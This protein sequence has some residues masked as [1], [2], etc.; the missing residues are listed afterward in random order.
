MCVS[1][2]VFPN[3]TVCC[4]WNSS[5]CIVHTFSF[6]FV[7]IF[8]VLNYLFFSHAGSYP[9]G[10]GILSPGK[11]A[12]ASSLPLTH[13]VPKLG[14]CMEP[15]LHSSIRLHGL[16]LR[17]VPFTALL[18][19]AVCSEAGLSNIVSC[20]CCRDVTYL[21]LHQRIF[22]LSSVSRPALGPTQPPLQW[23]P[24]VLSPGVKRG[25]GVMLTTHPPSSAE[26]VNE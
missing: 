1:R 3:I 18:R 24:G 25:R 8:F 21:S 17:K 26:V 23:V 15:Y 22:P 2:L 5:V 12:G 20:L 11:A 10:T 4:C 6:L 7:F 19:S 9:M 14:M 13:L 16:L